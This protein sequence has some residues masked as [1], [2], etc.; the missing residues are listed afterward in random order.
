VKEC[1]FKPQI[2]PVSKKLLLGKARESVTEGIRKK[3]S[4]YKVKIIYMT[5]NPNILFKAI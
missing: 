1:S 3:F 5:T 4:F 2:N